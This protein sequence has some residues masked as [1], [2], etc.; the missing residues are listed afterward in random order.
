M[1]NPAV[2]SSPKHLLRRFTVPALLALSLAC[3]AFAQTAHIAAVANPPQLK[4]LVFAVGGRVLPAAAVDA[5]FGQHE[6]VC[7][8]PATYF[9]AAF[10]GSAVY[11]E[12]GP[13]DQILHVTLDHQPPIALVSP[14]PG[15]YGVTGLTSGPHRVRIDV[16]TE[17]QAGPDTFVGFAIPPTEKPLNPPHRQR[18]IEFIGDSHT[19][20]YGNTSPTRDCSEHQVWATTDSSQ[21]FG[22][23]VA[24]H[25]GA[26]YQVNAISGH[27]IVRNYNGS[28]GDPVP[29]AYPYVLFDKKDPCRDPAW[30]PE[31]VVI[32]LGTNDFTTPLHPGEK[33]KTRDALH[34]DY[35]ATYLHFLQ[36]LRARYPRAFFILW[37]TNMAQGEIE[38]EERRVME[39]WKATGE[40]RVAFLPIDNL[41]FTACN[42]HPSLADDR[43][44]AADLEKVIDAQPGIWAGK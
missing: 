2:P 9:E 31:V 22:P 16:V 3:P 28:P 33:W 5:R 26:G 14:A 43:T 36:N 13:G 29:V 21:A 15:V 32:A 30:Q 8:W 42:W 6:Y 27:G 24:A 1:L 17:S 18:Q 37:A 12:T 25:Y 23:L 38:S 40:S 20:G 4:P 19:V 34:A 39:Q 10:Q 11:F 44:I 41:S 7:Q 35:E